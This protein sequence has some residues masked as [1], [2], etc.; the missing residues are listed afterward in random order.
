MTV[1]SDFQTAFSIQVRIKNNWAIRITQNV[2]M[3]GFS[4]YDDS[5]A[6]SN[7][8]TLYMLTTTS[9]YLKMWKKQ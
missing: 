2:N 5:A 7:I 4:E 1:T 3:I 8:K 9:G 6:P